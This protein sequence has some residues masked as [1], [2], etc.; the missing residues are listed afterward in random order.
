MDE[1]MKTPV[2][3]YKYTDYLFSGLLSRAVDEK[4][5]IERPYADDG[6]LVEGQILY[7]MDDGMR[8]ELCLWSD[9]GMSFWDVSID[10]A[11]FDSSGLADF[12]AYLASKGLPLENVRDRYG[13]WI[14]CGV[15]ENRAQYRV[16]YYEAEDPAP[17]HI[18]SIEY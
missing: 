13:R 2:L 10:K 9:G 5:L 4:S 6:A 11:E 8:V 16:Q 12:T 14:Y 18:P 15:I 3:Q 1:D 17:E 7:T